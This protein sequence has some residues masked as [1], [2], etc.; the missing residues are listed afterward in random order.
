MSFDTDE[1][2]ADMALRLDEDADVWWVALASVEQMADAVEAH[3]VIRGRLLAQIAAHPWPGV[4]RTGREL[5]QAL[6][7][8]SAAA[9]CA[10]VERALAGHV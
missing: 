3:P 7:M 8:R 9:A 2:R 4:Q 6:A 1:W 10:A 5:A